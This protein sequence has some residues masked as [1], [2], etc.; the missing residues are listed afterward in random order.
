MTLWLHKNGYSFF[1]IPKLT[2]GEIGMLVDAHNRKVKK[3]KQE[4]DRA[5]RKSKSKGK[6]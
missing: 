3:E 6:R 2:Y 4:S 5:N 1:T